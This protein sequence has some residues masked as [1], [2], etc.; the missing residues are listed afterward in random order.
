MNELDRR[1]AAT[2]RAA[3]PEP[4][5]ALADRILRLTAVAP[6]RRPWFRLGFAPPLAGAAVVILAVA[7]G[8]ALGRLLGPEGPQVGPPA[9][10]VDPSPS[11]APPASVVPSAVPTP[12]DSPSSAGTLR[13][14]NP[15]L[16][17]SVEYPAEWYANEAVEAGEPPSDP[18]AACQYFSEVP[19][20][21]TPNAGVPLSVAIQFDREPEATPPGGDVI[22]SRDVTVAGRPAMVREVAAVGDGPFLA[23]GDRI[24]EYLVELEEGDVLFA[25]T[26]STRFGDYESHRDVL[27]AMMETLELLGG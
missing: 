4:D 24:Y 17:Y 23:E 9:S 26:D 5:P 7:A 22:S 16:G 6:Q 10:S 2:L 15:E 11:G 12:T 14:D 20:E 13:C 18:I 8:L 1:I 25:S 21:L 3:A 27:D 19:V